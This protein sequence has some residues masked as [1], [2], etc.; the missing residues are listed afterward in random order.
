MRT[1]GRAT[2]TLL[3]VAAVLGI[4]SL[5]GVIADRAGRD[6]AFVIDRFDRQVRVADTG[7]LAV[8]ETIE[9][10]FSRSR[11]GIFRDLPV[12]GPRRVLYEVGGVDR[13]PGTE[14]WTW[15]TLPIPGGEGTRIRVGDPAVHLP[16]GTYTYRFVYDIRGL[17]FRHADQPDV[18]Q[19]RLDVPGF[20]W[21]TDIAATTLDVRLPA[22]AREVVCVSGLRRSTRRCDPPVRT[23]GDRVTAT[24]PSF[25]AG[26]AATVAIDLD[27]DAFT[28]P[29]PVARVQPLASTQG[30]IPP[31]ALPAWLAGLL[32]AVSLVLPF[33]AFEVFKAITVYRDERTD[34]HLHDRLHPTAIFAPPHGHG[35]VEVAG[36]LLRTMQTQPLLIGTLIDLD[37]R[38]VVRTTTDGPVG[39]TTSSD[40]VAFTVEPGPPDATAHPTERR[41]VSALMP[42]GGSIRFDGEYDKRTARRASAASSVLVEHAKKV[43]ARYGYAH[44]RSRWLRSIGVRVLMYAGIGLGLWLWTWI[45][46][47]LLSLPGGA[48]AAIAVVV[49]VGWLA[50]RWVWR[51]HRLPLNSRGRDAVAQARAFREFIAT[52]EGDQL[53]W[54]AG[55]PGID[56]HHPAVSLLPYAVVLGLADSWYERFGPLLAELAAATGATGGAWWASSRGFDGVQ[57]ASSGSTTSPSSGGSFGGGGGGSGGGGG[58]GGA[59]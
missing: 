41:F 53:Q 16:P 1:V 7:T 57:T 30:L 9:V 20:D 40:D 6:T 14:P 44:G 54:A 2:T 37:Q 42:G 33:T 36:L 29:L 50:T 56:H 27:T 43:F 23:S 32:L 8:V 28:N 38:G 55:Q 26:R 48:A 5:A 21:P 34:P 46:S 19:V 52:V 51:H 58:G 11:R 47:S 17:T 18:A 12:D 15:T 3:I 35:P 59:W 4:G 31:I 39:P 10:T 22:P 24:F 45:A 49:V 25:A 13:G